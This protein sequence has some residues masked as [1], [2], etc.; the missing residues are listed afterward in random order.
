MK[1]YSL[2]VWKD[3]FDV[4]CNLSITNGNKKIAESIENY[5]ICDPLHRVTLSGTRVHVCFSFKSVT[6]LSK[7]LNWIKETLDN[8]DAYEKNLLNLRKDGE[9]FAKNFMKDYEKQGE[10]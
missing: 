8:G 4:Y 9:N 6:E 7:I 5:L 3:S 1:I 10:N 2:T